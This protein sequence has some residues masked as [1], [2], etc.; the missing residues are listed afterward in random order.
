VF[1][2]GVHRLYKNV[3]K[4]MTGVSLVS[5]VSTLIVGGIGALMI[6]VGGGDILAGRMTLGD[7]FMYIFFTGL[8]AAPVVSITSIGTQVSEAFAGLDR[9][10]E[11]REMATE[12]DEDATRGAIDEI[13]AT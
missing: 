4:T 7:F 3:A 13:G 1:T 8:V 5:G 10:R 2:K 9:I 6:V 12:D 11:L